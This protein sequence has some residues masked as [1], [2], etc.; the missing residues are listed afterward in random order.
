MSYKAKAVILAGGR[1]KR[2]GEFTR[3]TQKCLLPVDGTPALLHVMQS[4]DESLGPVETIICV[5]Y[6]AASVEEFVRRNKPARM[7][8]SF[9]ADEGKSDD[10]SILS[11]LK[12]MLRDKFIWL[13]GDVIALPELYSNSLSTLTSG[14]FVGSVSLSPKLD[15]AT[16]HPIGKV[17]EGKIVELI[18]PPPPIFG[19]GYLR[20]MTVWALDTKIFRFMGNGTTIFSLLRR[21]MDVGYDVASNIYSKQWVH[22]GYPDDLRKTMTSEDN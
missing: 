3:N 6:G 9:I 7:E 18:Y 12:D 16:T 22:L 14:N 21:A 10:L 11:N 15:E 17:S 13:A 8:T 19:D 5:S 1:G 4:L 20:D 2:M